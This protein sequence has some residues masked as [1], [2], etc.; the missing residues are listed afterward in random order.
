[1]KFCYLSHLLKPPLA[2]IW[3]VNQFTNLYIAEEILD[4]RPRWACTELY[5][6]KWHCIPSEGTW[7]YVNLGLCYDMSC[8]FC[9]KDYRL[10]Q[11]RRRTETKMVVWFFDSLSAD[12]T[13]FNLTTYWARNYYLL[14]VVWNWV[15]NLRF[16]HPQKAGK[17]NFFTQFHATHG[18]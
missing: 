17:R 18:K 6:W 15:I 11:P 12:R 14:W 13:V 3:F 16:V 1:M 2:T 7:V 8:L 9:T 10:F 5:L 4:W